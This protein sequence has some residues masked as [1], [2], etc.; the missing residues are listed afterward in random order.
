M[1]DDERTLLVET[2]KFTHQL[3]SD[4][5]DMLVGITAALLDLYRTAFQDGRDTK[6][7][8]LTRLQMQQRSFPRTSV[9]WA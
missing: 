5:N 9:A 4:R 2:A 7:D 1:T 6:R 3:A 8:A